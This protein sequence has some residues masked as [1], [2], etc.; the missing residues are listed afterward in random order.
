MTAPT[1]AAMRAAGKHFKPGTRPVRTR[2]LAELIDAETGLPELISVCRSVLMTHV[3][4]GAGHSFVPDSC[5]EEIRSI[6]ERF[7]ATDG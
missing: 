2:E 3:P 5:I 4:G 7:G 1:A 6:L